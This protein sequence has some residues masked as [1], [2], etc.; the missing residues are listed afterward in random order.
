MKQGGSA[1]RVRSFKRHSKYPGS[2]LSRVEFVNLK[3][4]F[5]FWIYETF[6]ACPFYFLYNE[7]VKNKK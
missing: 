6:R 4:T 2:S 5:D 1:G 3:W 7:H